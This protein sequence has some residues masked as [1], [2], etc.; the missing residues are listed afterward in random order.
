MSGSD[1]RI[2]ML[3]L[4]RPGTVDLDRDRVEQLLV[5]RSATRS[6]GDRGGAADPVAELLRARQEEVPPGAVLRPVAE[7]LER[8]GLQLP[9][10][11]VVWVGEDEVVH[12]LGDPSV[13]PARRT[14]FGRG[15]GARPA[16]PASST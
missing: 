3:R 5:R 16:P 12:E 8:V 11:G 14:P 6:R 10:L 2:V 9:G 4:A 15:R 1:Q 7:L 13:V